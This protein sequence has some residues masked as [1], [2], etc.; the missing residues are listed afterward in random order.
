[1]TA[2]EQLDRWRIRV[3]GVVQGVGYRPFVYR[4]AQAHRLAGWVYNDP[5][6]VLVEVQGPA[7]KLSEFASGLR[8]QAPVLARVQTVEVQRGL[9]LLPDRGEGPGSFNI[10]ESP[11]AGARTTIVPA[12]S[13]VCADC[14]AE[15]RNPTDRRYRYPFINCTNCGPRYSI[16]NAL[17]YDRGQTT[18]QTFEMCADCRRE[19][20][21]PLDRRYH[22]QPNA[23]ASC[24][25]TLLLVDRQGR[26]TAGEGALEGAGAAL[27]AGQILA[28]KSLGG[29]HLAVNAR[30]PRAV[31]LLRMRKKRDAKPFAVMARDLDAA[32]R[33]ADFSPA[34]AELMES[35]ARPIVLVRK[36]PGG[37]TDLVAPRNPNVGVML[38]SAPQHHLLLDEPRLDVLVMTSG[39]ISGSPIVFRN[40]DALAQLFPI[41]DAI[42]L[43]DRDIAIRVDDSVV[44]YSDHPDL[45]EP[46]VT[47][48]RRARGYAPSPVDVG[49]TLAPLVAYGAEL[50]ST[51]ALSAGS[52]VYV[53]QHIGDVKNDETFTSHQR[54]AEHLAALHHLH[55][56]AAA[57]DLHP[58]FRVTRAAMAGRES[59]GRGRSGTSD[60][61]AGVLQVQHHHAHMA[62][63]MAENRL[64]GTTLGVIFDGAGYGTDGTIWGGEFLLGEYREVRRV[65]C[66]RPL[67]L[68]GG[69]TAVREPIRTGF[70]LALSAL[71]DAEAACTAFPVLRRLSAE[72]QRVYAAMVARGLNAPLTSS[73]GRLFDA[74][75]ALLGICSRAEYEAHGPIELEGLLD[76]DL[77]M[78]EPYGAFV[79]DVRGTRAGVTEIDQRPLVRALAADLAAGVPLPTISRRFHSAVVA[80]VVSHCC[81]LRTA[82]GVEQV[83][84]SGG[85]FLNEFLL[86][87]C[88]VQLRRAGF[89]VYAHR[90]V[91]PNDGGISLG[92]AMVAN[93]LLA[94]ALPFPAQSLE[95]PP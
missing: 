58:Q 64:T 43:H 1:V 31:S 32:A 50:K 27:A 15:L 9:E 61:P 93:A 18:M 66:L 26:R 41:A 22:A 29:F 65:A 53:S 11:A 87:N 67:P 89:D 83:V 94:N 38:P 23:C 70:A 69:D 45:P 46:V 92:Q 21:D 42:L 55:P 59:A 63:C 73:M 75:A 49:T 6:G 16:V 5:Q 13:Y 4:L 54:T 79:T 84:L 17:P 62:S 48:L 35:P 88:L 8:A 95:D 20:T 47:F 40:D 82:E 90:L 80:L 74:V 34:E 51:V 3:N 25:P 91:P 33:I 12:D 30:D 78:A 36:R 57:C 14:L 44:R 68:L 37:L 10:C 2:T 76:R 19:Y 39:N 85:V 81:A 28:V 71:G 86:V 52:R 60:S 7:S 77:S 56:R 72:Q 24:G